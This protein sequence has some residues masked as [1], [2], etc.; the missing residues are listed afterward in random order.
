MKRNRFPAIC[1]RC[2]NEVPPN[3]GSLINKERGRWSVACGECIAL[4]TPQSYAITTWDGENAN[5]TYRNRNGR[6]ED[7]PCCGCCS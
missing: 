1:V 7:A 4:D 6:C 2:L 5:F 3:C